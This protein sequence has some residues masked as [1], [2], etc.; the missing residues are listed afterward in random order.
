MTKTA[1]VL[2]IVSLGLLPVVA[3][4]AW[5]RAPLL[6]MCALLAVPLSSA[7]AAYSFERLAALRWLGFLAN[8]GFALVMAVAFAFM[9]AHVPPPPSLVQTLPVLLA[10]LVLLATPLANV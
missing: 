4:F 8:L 2:T 7:L 10:A 1:K 6:V 5:P 3:W 9:V